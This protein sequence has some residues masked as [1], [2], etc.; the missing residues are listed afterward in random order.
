M[1]YFLRFLIIWISQNLAIPF[2]VVGHVHLHF[3]NY[4]DML[5]YSGSLLM[6]LI[7]AFGFY[8]DYKDYRK[9]NNH[10][11]VLIQVLSYN[12]LCQSFCLSY[13][14]SSIRQDVQT[15]TFP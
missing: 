6:H 3:K 2:W 9:E 4:H 7:V 15:G 11:K 12:F 14:F 8:L 10:D 1:W 13:L 5:E